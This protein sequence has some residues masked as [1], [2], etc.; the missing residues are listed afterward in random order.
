MQLGSQHRVPHALMLCGNDGVG[1]MALALAFASYLLTEGRRSLNPSLNIQMQEAMLRGWAHPDLH[2]CYPTIKPK[3]MSSDRQPLAADFISAWRELLAQGPYFSMEQ[4]M[5]AMGAENQQA[6]I[7]AAQADELARALSLK[8]SQGGYKVAVVWQPERMNITC[9]NK[10]LKL[11]EEPPS[12][13][14]FVMVS[15]HPEALL[16]T[17]RSRTQRIDVRPIATADLQQALVQRRG[18]DDDT[19][20]RVARVAAGSWL[21]AVATLDAGNER[22]QLF[23]MF[24]M[25]MRLAYMRNVKELKK[26]TDAVATYGR[27]KQRR[28]LEYFMQLVR[29]NFMH[30][31]H[32]SELCYM[33]REEEAFAEKFAPFINEANVV[34]M[35]ELLAAAYHD[36]GQNANAK[37]VFYDMSLKMIVLLRRQ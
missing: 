8:A 29:E 30:N 24:T 22:R 23:D 31:F 27:E 2:F 7:N 12:Q 20:R 21:K 17:I 19:A 37:I 11:L 35:N 16:E 32:I 26:W 14:V 15:S 28:M 25:L 5:E 6:I 18:L 4:W 3:S 9:A 34:E 13:T 10:I 36:I 33:T 1:K